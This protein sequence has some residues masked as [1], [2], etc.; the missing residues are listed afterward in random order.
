MVSSTNFFSEM[1]AQEIPLTA[2]QDTRGGRESSELVAPELS[3]DSAARPVGV[4]QTPN[5]RAQKWV[6]AGL[7]IFV[8]AIAVV[9]AATLRFIVFPT[10]DQPRHVDAIVSFNGSNEGTRQAVAVALAKKGYAPVILF[11]KGS[12]LADTPCPKVSRISV[13]C[14]V[15][16]TGNTR[17]E[18]EWVGRYAQRHHWHS[19]LLVPGRGQATRARLLTE[20]CF[21]GNLVVVPADEPRPPLSQIVHEWGGLFDAVLINRS[22]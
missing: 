7:G 14:F 11:S 18:A 6:L 20:R 16:V 19:L 8:L 2:V 4:R 5:R 17:G 21:P 12:A 1:F 15:D 3:G 10:V 13:V 22:C 9:A